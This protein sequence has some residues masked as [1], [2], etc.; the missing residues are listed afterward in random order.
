MPLNTLRFLSQLALK[1]LWAPR[2]ALS[3]VVSK[4]AIQSLEPRRLFSFDITGTAGDDTFIISVADDHVIHLNFNGGIEI[5]KRSDEE[6]I[7]VLGFGGNDTIWLQNTGRLK[8]SLFGHGGSDKYTVGSGDLAHDIRRDVSVQEADGPNL[9]GL[10][11]LL[12]DD[13]VSPKSTYT[14]DGS[15]VSML[16]ISLPVISFPMTSDDK[17]TLKGGLGDDIAEI[18]HLRSNMTID[19]GPGDDLVD[20]GG[21][22][23]QVEASFPTGCVIDPGGGDDRLLIDDS[24]P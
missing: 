19:M 20:F 3:P 11:T 4:V 24:S 1:M 5:V 10:D 8:F 12:I 17:I 15:Q 13:S 9:G 23:H 21:P 16:S 7:N 6:F 2:T 18:R 22:D 14:I